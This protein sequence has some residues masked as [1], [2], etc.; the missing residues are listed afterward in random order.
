MIFPKVKLASVQASPVFLDIDASI[1]K[2]CK[3]IEDAANNGA[4]LVGFPEAFLPGYPWW[5]W[6]GPPSFGHKYLLKLYENALQENSP[7]MRKLSEAARKNKIYVCISATEADG[8]TLYLTQFWFDKKGNLIGKHRKM[9]PPGCEKI[10]WACGDGSTMQV[11]D[12]EIGKIGGIMCGEHLNPMN[13]SALLGQ[14]EQIHVA[15]WPPMHVPCE[16]Q[17]PLF[18]TLEMSS[19]CTRYAAMGLR[20]FAIYSTQMMGQDVI[21]M[22]CTENPEFIEKL[23]SGKDGVIGGGHSAIYNILGEKISNDLPHDVEGIVY[24]DCDLK[25]TLGRRLVMDPLDKDARPFALSMNLNR[26]HYKA[27]NFIGE[28]PDNSISYEQIQEL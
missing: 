9:S 21:D 28:Q 13:I 3:F 1:D 14:G 12:T 6:M 10:V 27:M 15:G 19:M 8:T 17:K 25:D 2:A 23:P 22:L 7:Q 20:A 18:S 5:I 11:F 16:G 4:D 24:A 26:T